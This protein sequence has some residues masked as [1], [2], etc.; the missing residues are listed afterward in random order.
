[1]KDMLDTE[2]LSKVLR[3]VL[4]N[5]GEYADIFEEERRALTVHL[6]D[7]KIEK[8]VS[9]LDCGVGIRLISGGK[10]AYAFSND[11][12]EDS[13]IE[14]ADTLRST[15][16]REGGDIVLDLRKAT[17]GVDFTIEKFPDEVPMARKIGLLKEAN[18]AARAYDRSV[19]QVS[20]TY[21]DSIQKVRIATS[22]G[23]IADDERIH[24][25][26]IVN[27]IAADDKGSVQT[28][29]ETAGGH[30]GFELFDGLPAEELALRASSRSVMMLRARRAPGGRMPVVISSEAGGTLIHE[31]IGHGLEADLAQAGL[32]VYSHKTGTEV[33]SGIV[34]VMD[35]ATLPGKRGSYR[36]DDEGT[37]SGRTILVDKGVLVGYMYDRLTAMGDAVKST[38]NGRRESYRHRPIPRMSNTFIAPGDAAPEDIVKSTPAGLFVKKMGGGQVNTVTGDFVF[39]VQEGYRIENGSIGEPL[40]GATLTGNGP[41]VLRSIDIVASDLGFSIGT[42]RKDSQGV[43][44]SDAMPTVRIREMVVGGEVFD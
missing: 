1:M 32:S 23:A 29:Y 33:A 8:V 5:G 3:E 15:F 44:V 37:P 6:E 38:G 42:C 10:T 41:E 7:E 22:A 2:V 34:T 16:R 19:R 20:V 12:S 35:D 25:L 14:L 36:F 26:C 40:R 27:V 21:R 39:D 17:P 30:I 43:P 13:L 18:R 4:S 28:G 11:S 31:A 9:G 24:T